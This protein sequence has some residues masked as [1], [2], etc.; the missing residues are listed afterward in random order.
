MHAA[1][2]LADE[3]SRSD[4]AGVPMAFERYDR[5]CRRQ[6]ERAQAESRRLGRAM[7]VR[8]PV[9]AR[10]RDH[11]VQRYPA[12]LALRSIINSVHQPF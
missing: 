10:L 2:G 4:A 6:A 9:T 7:F 8:H 5:R 1:A 3:L 12:S 11:V